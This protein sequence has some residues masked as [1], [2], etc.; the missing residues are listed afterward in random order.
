MRK[1]RR[2]W[3]ILAV[4]FILQI[5]LPG[6]RTYAATTS[7]NWYKTVMGS[8]KGKY[9]I[10]G[11]TYKRADYPFGKVLDINGDGIKELILCQSDMSGGDSLSDQDMLL[12][13]YY[14]G[15]VKPLLALDGVH[16]YLSYNKNK[17]V[18]IVNSDY[19]GRYLGSTVYQLKSGKLKKAANIYAWTTDGPYEK[20]GKTCSAAEY[21]K[22]YNTYVKN[23][24]RLTYTINAYKVSAKSYNK[25][26][27]ALSAQKWIPNNSSA[28]KKYYYKV[29][30]NTWIRYSKKT[31]KKLYS[32]K[33]KAV[34]NVNG[35]FA[36]NLYGTKW[37]PK[38]FFVVQMKNGKAAGVNAV[39]YKTRSWQVWS[40]NKSKSSSYHSA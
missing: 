35:M 29:K 39:S 24:V 16:T 26:M 34:Y 14:K 25:I 3:W 21:K 33:I 15:K 32:K 10:S 17:K 12:L 6:G 5:H 40:M 30:N 23:A 22:I 31:G 20:S 28:A 8:S 1:V 18:L 27:K 7:K 19:F 9:K 11:R 36:V 37:N 38:N 2:W 4:I 13:T